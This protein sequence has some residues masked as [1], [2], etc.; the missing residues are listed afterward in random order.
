MKKSSRISIVLAFLFVSAATASVFAL[1]DEDGPGDKLNGWGKLGKAVSG[2][3]SFYDFSFYYKDERG[4]KKPA[5]AFVEISPAVTVYYDRVMRI[6]DLKKGAKVRLFARAVEQEVRGGPPGGGGGNVG[7]Q[8]RSGTDRQIQNAQIVILG[9][10]VEVNESY[11]HP[12]DKKL[13]WIDATVESSTSGLAVSYQGNTYRVTID[14]K[15]PIINR[16]K[17]EHKLLKKARYS[18][19]VGSSSQTRPKTKSRSDASKSSFKS[20][21]VIILDARA[22]KAFP[23]LFD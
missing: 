16:T 1:K 13:K 22:A 5:K 21:R 8:G 2:S 10:A 11:E 15:A 6:Q 18:H 4:R 19:V 23:L 12:K 7:Q 20:K 3:E 17:V 9:E 14:R